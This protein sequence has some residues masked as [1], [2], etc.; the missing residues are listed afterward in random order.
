MNFDHRITGIVG[1]IQSGEY[2]DEL[3]FDHKKLFQKKY[4]NFQIDDCYNYLDEV[5][6]PARST[7]LRLLFKTC[8]QWNWEL[9]K[10]DQK[11]YLGIWLYEPRLPKSEVVCAIGKKLIKYYQNEALDSRNKQIKK[12]KFRFE[13]ELKVSLNWSQKIDYN[14]LEKWEIDFPKK[15]YENEDLYHQEQK[16][17]QSFIKNSSK[18]IPEDKGE[19]IKAYGLDVGSIWVGEKIK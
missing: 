4:L 2:E 18:I 12:P 10:L 8:N 15:N 9:E 6:E 16:R 13:E 5:K 3:K 19:G 11:F 17:F 14:F 1:S 7:I